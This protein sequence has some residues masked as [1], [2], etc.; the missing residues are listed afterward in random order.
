MGT[1]GCNV[2]P[3]E[4]SSKGESEMIS[5]NTSSHA[6]SSGEPNNASQTE[7]S[8]KL[9]T[10]SKY[11]ESSSKPGNASQS[12]RSSLSVDEI[13]KKTAE[14]YDSLSEAERD[15]AE[16]DLD[17]YASTYWNGHV[18][19]NESVMFLQAEDGSVPAVPLMYHADKIL[20]VR[21]ATLGTLYKEGVDYALEDGKLVC[22]EGSSMTTVRYKTYYPDNEIPNRT[23]PRVGGGYIA[24]S[25]GVLFHNR[26]V[27][28][29]YI[30][31]DQWQGPVPEYKGDLLPKTISKLKKKE[32]IQ[33]VLYG[34]S[35]STG[36]N[37]S[38]NEK[39]APYAEGWFDMMTGKLKQVYGTDKIH[40]DNK[41]V[42]GTVSNWGVS[43]A[44]EVADLKPDL[45]IL[46]FGMNDGT[47]N[48]APAVFEAN[49]KS[50]MSSIRKTN[51][52]CEFILISTMLPNPE[53]KEQ[54]GC[55]EDYVPVIQHLETEGV[56]MAN[57]TEV[58]KYLMGLKHYYDMTGNN[59]NHP[60]DFVA[61]LY[62]QI[63]LT[64]LVENYR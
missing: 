1:A 53:A 45:V 36:A 62:T 41:A 60:N 10:T 42:G 24:F 27:A 16:Y 39:S 8:S 2:Q 54:F 14:I 52:D 31:T 48:V 23:Q 13:A 21:D 56:A 17:K 58:H 20:A 51:P 11:K 3:T 28:V 35:I 25:E 44:G 50:M 26:Q 29:T 22:L 18:V 6:E 61:R 4:E 7:S 34:D 15:C 32:D 64:T 55:Q 43:N 30:H 57:V 38:G 47:F 46:G 40:F 5:S 33:I 37:S 63:M 59:V 19:Y 49:L 9:G 12:T